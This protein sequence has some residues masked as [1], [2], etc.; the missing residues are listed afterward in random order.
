MTVIMALKDN[1]GTIV[2]GADKQTT[3]Y[4]YLS[5]ETSSKVVCKKVEVNEEL[6]D[7]KDI[8]IL[9]TGIAHYTDYLTYVF[10][11][12]AIDG[13]ND[14]EYITFFIR[15]FREEIHEERFMKFDD[16]QTHFEGGMIIIFNNNI[17]SVENNLGVML[18]NEC[19][20]Q[21]IGSEVAFGSLYSTKDEPPFQRIHI[22]LDA[23]IELIDGVG[24]GKTVGIIQKEE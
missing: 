9:L 4:G 24:K 19:A 6:E 11:P 12:P 1:D 5:R 18:E 20:V 13:M 23:C 2:Y 14:F 17:Y 21:G 10:K 22:A 15:T 3:R 8:T 16:S 7:T